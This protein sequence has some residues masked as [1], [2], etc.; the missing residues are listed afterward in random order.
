MGVIS[1]EVYSGSTGE[2][3]RPGLLDGDGEAVPARDGPGVPDLRVVVENR[4]AGA[5][6]VQGVGEG[7]HVVQRGEGE[8][9]Q[10]IGPLAVGVP[11][12]EGPLAP[13]A[14]E[15]VLVEEAQ[16]PSHADGA[17]DVEVEACLPDVDLGV[18]GAGDR[19]DGDGGGDEPVLVPRWLEVVDGVQLGVA[20]DPQQ[21]CG[22]REREEPS[23]GGVQ[24]GVV[25]PG[26]AVR[27]VGHGLPLCQGWAQGGQ[28]HDLRGLLRSRFHFGRG[29]LGPLELVDLGL[30]LLH[31]LL[32]DLHLVFQLLQLVLLLPR[33]RRRRQDQK[34]SSP[35][36][37][38]PP[39]IHL[40]PPV[41]SRQPRA[42][43][44]AAFEGPPAKRGLVGS[45][46]R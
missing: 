36:D 1:T 2:D 18:V 4:A 8:A 31:H 20:A 6:E 5:F 13:R 17:A 10:K 11:Q 16:V 40:P 19:F 23:H 29:G 38:K 21:G 27:V 46:A 12:V 33:A 45:L 9:R 37:R 34:R 25:D 28:R 26:D 41:A 7:V 42:D 3:V 44:R 22:V 15:V 35:Q 39:L 43:R 30:H 14:R 24:G 32:H